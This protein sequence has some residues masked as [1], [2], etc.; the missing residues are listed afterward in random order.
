VENFPE[1]FVNGDW[2]IGDWNL[3]WMLDT[4]SLLSQG[5]AGIAGCSRAGNSVEG[6]ARENQKSK[7]K[8][9]NYKLK[10]KNSRENPQGKLGGGNNDKNPQINLGG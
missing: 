7:R 9:Q 5:Q 10:I 3:G 2:L 6:I 8:E 4:G 1:Y